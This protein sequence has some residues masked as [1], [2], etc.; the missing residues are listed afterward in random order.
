MRDAVGT[1]QVFN[2]NGTEEV[3]GRADPGQCARNLHWAEAEQC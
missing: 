2:P 1:E 3:W